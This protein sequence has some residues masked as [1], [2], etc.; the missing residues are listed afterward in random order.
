MNA[1]DD[2]DSLVEISGESK[3]TLNAFK[4]IYNG[5]KFN[6][7]NLLQIFKEER[8]KR[9]NNMTEASQFAKYVV[10]PFDSCSDL[11]DLIKKY[12][13]VTDVRLDYSKPIIIRLDGHRFSKVF[14]D[15]EKPFDPRRVSLMTDLTKFLMNELQARFGY[16]QSDEITLVFY[17]KN[18]EDTF[19]NARLQK[20]CSLSASLAASFFAKKVSEYIPEIAD[21]TAVFDSRVFNVD[22]KSEAVLSVGWRVIDSFKNAILSLSQHEFGHKRIHGLNIWQLIGTLKIEKNID[23]NTYPESFLYGVFLYRQTVNQK[24]TAEDIEKLPEKHE[25]RKNPDLTF[26]RNVVMITSEPIIYPSQSIEVSIDKIF[27]EA[28]K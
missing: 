25:A 27:N 1:I 6:K 10:S 16:T 11:G 14:K 18:E 5:D 19:F 7:K 28:S 17:R 22:T 2:L 15:L 20:L 21:K 12:E 24:F 8:N 4:A 26:S 13:S 3:E 23:I 9:M